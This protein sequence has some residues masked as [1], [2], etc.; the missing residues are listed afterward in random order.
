MRSKIRI[1]ADI[2]PGTGYNNALRGLI[3]SLEVLGYTP[4]NVHVIGAATSM[5]Y[6]TD[7]N[8]DWL[9]PYIFG[10]WECDDKINIVHLNPGMVGDYWTSVGG[11]VNIAYCAWETDHLPR[12]VYPVNGVDRTCAGDLNKFD[13]V[14]VPSPFLVKIFRDSGVTAPIH[15]MPHALQPELLARPVKT[16][17]TTTQRRLYTIGSWNDRKNIRGLL[18]AYLAT[19]LSPLDMTLL[20]HLVPPTRDG[21]AIEAHAFIAKEQTTQLYDALPTKDGPGFGLLTV[22]R[23]YP[24]ILDFHA[25]NDLFVTAS[26]GE[27]FCLPALE[28]LALGNAVLGG[29]GPWLTDLADAIGD[30]RVG[31]LYLVPTQ[32]VEI[33]PMPECRGYE[34][35]Q[36]WWEPSREAFTNALLGAPII[37]RPEVAQRVRDLF[38]PTAIAK[39]HLA[40]R[41]EE[42]EAMLQKTG[43]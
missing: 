10:P 6:Q 13:Q 28:A 30:L 17:T 2:N 12:K 33:T 42:A 20:M 43:W 25:Q 18:R 26:R 39:N 23:P 34:L 32:L 21:H 38:C 1:F 37:G 14:W 16:Y 8:R 24:W 4:E 9:E 31:A 41:L 40:A 29:G 19:G 15:V 35:D 27:G 22:P 3:R 5:I 11:R 36:R 7:D